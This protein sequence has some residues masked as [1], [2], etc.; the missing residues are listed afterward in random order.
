MTAPRPPN[1]GPCPLCEGCTSHPAFA[2]DGF[3]YFRCDRCGAARLAPLPTPEAQKRLFD[4]SYFRGA[5][6]GGYLDY[7]ADEA[8]HRRNARDRLKAIARMQP[9]APGSLLDVGCANGYFLDEA[10]RAGWAV[11]GVEVSEAVRSDASRRFDLTV[12][13]DLVDALAA[14]AARFDVV[15]FYQALEHLADPLTALRQAHDLLR[16]GGCLLVE[17]WDLSS[18]VARA[19]GRYWQQISPPSVAYL[20]DRDSL[21]LLLSRAGF[22]GVRIRATGKRVR[23]GFG[24]HLLAAKLPRLMGP[25]ARLAKTTGVDRATVRY[26][27]GD[28]V[29]AFA[30]P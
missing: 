4:P 11:E 9:G 27:L 21:E 23:L 18:L 20:F 26:A 16:P 28:L 19:S 8:V 5:A 17:T 14:G 22:R 7:T 6:P 3:T 24:F 13:P 29:T 10:A 12:R 30:R 1:A 2:V 25:V 15:T